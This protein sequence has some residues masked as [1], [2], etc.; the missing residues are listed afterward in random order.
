MGQVSMVKHDV[1]IGVWHQPSIIM[2]IGFQDNSRA[3]LIPRQLLRETL[4]THG[5]GFG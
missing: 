1:A 4:G 5:E 3:P 2:D